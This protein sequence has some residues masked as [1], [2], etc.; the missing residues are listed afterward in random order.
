MNAR[1]QAIL[2]HVDEL[3]TSEL[4]GA[5]VDHG[6]GWVDQSGCALQT[7]S[8]GAAARKM[9]AD[10]FRAAGITPMAAIEAS[11]TASLKFGGEPQFRMKF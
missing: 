4:S 1:L 7:L 10:P 5:E 8:A 3:T 11:V 9:P 2:T 6:S